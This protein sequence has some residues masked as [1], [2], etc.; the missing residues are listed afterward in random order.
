MSLTI[1]LGDYGSGKTA[2]AKYLAKGNDGVYIDVDLLS[3]R[4]GNYDTYTL[5]DKLKTIIKPGID[6]YMD[7]FPTGYYYGILTSEIL[8][9]KLKYIVCMTTP[10]IVN[11]RQ[12]KKV[13]GVST[14]L[15]RSYD[16]IKG[17][18]HLCASIALT[19]DENPLFADTTT[20][21]PTFW[22]KQ[23]WFLRWMEINLYASL[24]DADEY[25]DVE[26]R[27]R[28]IVGLS[29]SYKTWGRLSTMIDFKGKSVIDYGCNYGY[30]CFKAEE[31]GAN[32]IIGVDES[33]SVL[34]MATSIAMTKKSQA[35]FITSKLKDFKPP[36]TDIVMALNVLHHINY[37]IGIINNM[38]K[39]AGMVVLEMPAKDLPIIEAVARYYRFPSPIIA[40][41]HRVGRCIVICSRAKPVV[42]PKRFVYHPRRTA[43]TKWLFHIASKFIPKIDLTRKIKRFVW[44][45][46][47]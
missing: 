3:Q 40:N 13:S 15:P 37:D 18:T 36:D 35:K 23:D 46:L 7:G 27:D 21:P 45:R 29:K 10:I 34:N 11:Q 31:A 6:Y 43:F 32:R 38:F 30:F 24:R 14:L 16:E 26:L 41:S 8:G 28:T 20:R 19:Y 47:K 9:V 1:L 5:V 4:K 44:M 39:C 22:R 12:T 42:L 2:T 25:Q 33:Q 17:I